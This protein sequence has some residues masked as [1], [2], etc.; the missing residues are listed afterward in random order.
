MRAAAGYRAAWRHTSERAS[1]RARGVMLDSPEIWLMIG[2][3]EIARAA[4]WHGNSARAR[5]RVGSA[6]FSMDDL[7]H[8][9]EVS[10]A[11]A[12]PPRGDLCSY[13]LQYAYT[14]SRL[15]L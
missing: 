7:L 6:R 9:E 8:P 11:A 14:L 5:R 3:S 1:E 12:L 13:L 4:T 2:R 15:A 10:A